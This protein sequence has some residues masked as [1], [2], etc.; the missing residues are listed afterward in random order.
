MEKRLLQNN[1]SAREPDYSPS[2]M[3]QQHDKSTR[4][5]R[6]V[7]LT[8]DN[9]E[10][11]KKY[12]LAQPAFGPA[13]E[14]LIEGFKLLDEEVEVHIVSCLQRRPQH[15]PA[16]LGKN[17]FFHPLHVPNIG[18]L[19]TGYQGCVRAV[20]RKLRE[21]HPDIVHGQGT[22]R[23]CAVCAVLSGYPN[24]LTIHGH[25]SRIAE[26][27]HAK[28]LT[29]YW[30]AEKLERFCLRKTGGVV[31]LTG[32]TK[33]KVAPYARKTWTVPNAVHPSFF[34]VARSPADPPRVLCVA[35]VHLW[36]NQTGLIEAM[37]PLQAD[38]D[39][40]LIFVGSGTS[41]DPYFRKFSRMIGCRPW[42]Q[43][44]GSLQRD[45]LRN[46]MSHAAL[47]IL[48]SFEDNCPMVVIEAAAA[49]LPFAA[50]KVGGVS[51]LIEDGISGLL[52]NASDKV[53]MKSVVA[54]MLLDRA[55]AEKMGQKA[56]TISMQRF[57]PMAIARQHLGIYR[58]MAK[59]GD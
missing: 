33:Q 23:D 39:F 24:V 6:I 46:Q 31:C 38:H 18:W 17:I 32:Y 11:Q 58:E 28:P 25:M 8:N 43:Y 59:H 2:V 14:A 36:K 56:R 41:S 7:L 4:A 44:L 54:R 5:M 26:L 13:P 19:R 40:A 3:P 47:G 16:K 1:K 49:A 22:E 48:P 57:S 53:E 12:H 45:D 51:D 42:C 52:F 10:I 9:R 21:I 50:A 35:N 37:E 27:T 34:D 55:G 20:R 15:S 29:Y 30:L